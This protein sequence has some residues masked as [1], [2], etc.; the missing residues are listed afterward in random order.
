MKRFGEKY[1]IPESKFGATKKSEAQIASEKMKKQVE[2]FVENGGVIQQID[3]MG[4]VI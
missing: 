1:D 4:D 2:D 3:R